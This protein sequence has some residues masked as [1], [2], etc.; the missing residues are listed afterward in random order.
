MEVV[1]EKVVW[2]DVEM[3][4]IHFDKKKR[5]LEYFEIPDKLYEEWNNSIDE[6]WAVQSKI[7]KYKSG[8]LLT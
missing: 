3:L 5:G 1:S 7:K 4:R 8:D 6:F 2:D